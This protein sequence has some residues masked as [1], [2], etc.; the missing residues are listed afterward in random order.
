MRACQRGSGVWGV[1]S[2]LTGDDDP[3][4]GI[5]VHG[6]RGTEKQL[7]RLDEGRDY[8]VDGRPALGH[9]RAAVRFPRVEDA[10]I[11]HVG[12]VGV[13]A[14]DGHGSQV[15]G[16]LCE[17]VDLVVVVEREDV[18]DDG[19]RAGQ[20]GELGEPRPAPEVRR[21]RELH[22]V[23]AKAAPTAP[24]VPIVGPRADAGCEGVAEGRPAAANGAS[25]VLTRRGGR[26]GKEERRQGEHV[27]A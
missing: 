27:G 22:G 25:K 8:A 15:V 26:A 7:V 19:A 24:A 1:A 18:G 10:S 13:V 20:E 9:C 2:I 12:E 21:R 3:E 16:L 5:A 14:A 23:A 17:F 11:E 4:A 6:V